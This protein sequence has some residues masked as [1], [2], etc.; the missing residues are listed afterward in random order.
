ME[1][2]K[3][4][5]VPERLVVS[6]FDDQLEEKLFE[7]GLP[8]E[9]KRK[10]REIYRG[11]RLADL[12]YD[13]IAK[14]IFSPDMHPERME[15]ILQRTMRDKSVGVVHS[16]A[17]ENYLGSVYS[18]KTISD[19]PAWLKDHRL[20]DLEIQR[21]AQEYI[22]DRAD[23]YGSNMLLLQYSVEDGEAKAEIDY[24]N[25]NSA[26]IIVLMVNS[27][28]VFREYESDRYIHRITTAK[29]DSGIEFRM[30]KQMVFV[31]LDKA[32]AL[33]E[34]GG[35]NEDEDE[36]LLKMFALIADINNE[37]VRNE[38]S[39]DKF[40][41]DIRE[42]VFEFTRSREVQLMIL[43]DDLAIMD[44]NSTK[45]WEREEGR[46]EGRDEMADLIRW[47]FGQDRAD[48]VQKAVEDKAYLESLFEEYSKEEAYVDQ[49]DQNT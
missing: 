26:I 30:K 33:Y 19:L 32:L 20:V 7:S 18:K 31:Q 2:E 16:A 35:Y 12:Y 15:Y 14:H 22:Y 23:I 38:T 25:V 1:K 11:E 28:K 27:P 41:D 29:A 21:V 46:E 10:I 43:A 4:N 13:A 40:F 45:K 34:S 24:K 39:G 37:K 44:W 47:L 3:L 5:N 6:D 9:R 17:N 49:D 42:E 48:D 36:E 8:E